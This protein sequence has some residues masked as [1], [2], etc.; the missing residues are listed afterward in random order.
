MKTLANFLL[1]REYKNLIWGSVQD[2]GF[3]PKAR[4]GSP[5]NL[6]FGLGAQQRFF[7]AWASIQSIQTSVCSSMCG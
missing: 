7:A 2:G 4:R 6:Q 1:Y 3:Q 5:Q